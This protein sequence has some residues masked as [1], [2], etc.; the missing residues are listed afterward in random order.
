MHKKGPIDLGELQ[1]A[2]DASAELIQ[3]RRRTTKVLGGSTPF[4]VKQEPDWKYLQ[5][6]EDGRI[7]KEKVRLD[8]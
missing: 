8:V 7:C 3:E 1:E 6:G 4:P 5:S 2:L